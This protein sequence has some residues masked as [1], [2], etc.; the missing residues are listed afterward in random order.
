MNCYLPGKIAKRLPS[1]NIETQDSTE[2]A[3]T[4]YASKADPKP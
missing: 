2:P 1:F 4:S 3:V